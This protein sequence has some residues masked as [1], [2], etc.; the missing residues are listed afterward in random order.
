MNESDLPSLGDLPPLGSDLQSLLRDEQAAPAMPDAMAA[1]IQERLAISLTG[2]P[3]SAPDVSEAASATAATAEASNGILATLAGKP[4]LIAAA[5]F[6]TGIG[7]GVGGTT[8]F[9]KN[10]PAAMQQSAEAQ[11]AVVL[12]DAGVAALPAYDA[13]PSLEVVTP[14]I[15]PAAPA[16]L[17]SKKEVAPPPAPTQDRGLAAERALIEL[18]RTAL[19][20]RD[21]KTALAHLA[22]HASGFATGRLAEERDAL[23]IQAYVLDHAYTKAKA[24]A[25]VFETRYPK[26]VFLPVV[27]NVIAELP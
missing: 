3:L 22:E 27:R 17:P 6:T 11:V 7:V 14:V 9:S 18:S 2:V 15:E 4:L 20:R 12:I 13:A 24:Q 8:Y 5:A 21:A 26:S 19:T 10:A 1:R 23:R 25:K 16:R